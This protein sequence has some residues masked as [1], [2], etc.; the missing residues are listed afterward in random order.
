MSDFKHAG[1]LLN[2]YFIFFYYIP[3]SLSTKHVTFEKKE[4]PNLKDTSTDNSNER[5]MHD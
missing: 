2:T 1:F 4:K 3:E 5:P